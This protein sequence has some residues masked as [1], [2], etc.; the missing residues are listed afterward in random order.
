M[1]HFVLF[2]LLMAQGKKKVHLSLIKILWH[3]FFHRKIFNHNLL[4]EPTPNLTIVKLCS[5]SLKPVFDLYSFMYLTQN[6]THRDPHKIC[7][8]FLL[9]FFCYCGCKGSLFGSCSKFLIFCVALST[10][11]SKLS[12]S[13]DLSALK[14]TSFTKFPWKWMYFW[15]MFRNMLKMKGPFCAS[16]LMSVSW[17]LIFN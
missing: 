14:K 4:E 11:T 1:I 5:V 16:H 7:Y 9:H 15:K 8:N 17:I 2:V 10:V 6:K 3:F 13:L 12:V